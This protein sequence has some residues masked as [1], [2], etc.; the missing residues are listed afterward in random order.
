MDG[1]GQY[2]LATISVAFRSIRTSMDVALVVVDRLTRAGKKHH[3]HG[4]SYSSP[5]RTQPFTMPKTSQ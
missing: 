2:Q 4:S 5:V 1:A 3:R